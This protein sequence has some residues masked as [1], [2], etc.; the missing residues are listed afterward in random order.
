MNKT[1]I[2]FFKQKCDICQEEFFS[3]RPHYVLKFVQDNTHRIITLQRNTFCSIGC[4]TA[5]INAL[6]KEKRHCFL[7]NE[8][9]TIKEPRSVFSP[10]MNQEVY[11]CSKR[12]VVIYI[13][14]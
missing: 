7:C 4:V 8:L 6:E 5:F 1:E 12:C 13:G 2:K 9:I 14:K 3:S 11:F 10:T